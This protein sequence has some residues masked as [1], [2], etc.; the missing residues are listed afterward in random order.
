[1]IL[2]PSVEIIRLEEN[3]KFGTFGALKINKELF[4]LTLEPPD[5]LNQKN[6]SSIPAQQ[7]ECH[8][9]D[10]PKFGETF[11]IENVPFRDLVLFH[12]GNWVT[13]TEG[14]VIVGS[15]IMKLQN[16]VTQRGIG[17]SGDTF[18]KFMEVLS[19]Y[20]KFKL[21]IVNNL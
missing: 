17:N 4:C 14:C 9:H 2:L 15:S 3:F 6:I 5:L 18:K 20:E 12:K 16:E 13:N 8:L 19:P 7:Y 1:M 21:T 10:S 11:I